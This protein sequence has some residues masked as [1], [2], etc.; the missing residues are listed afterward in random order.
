MSLAVSALDIP[1]LIR[2]NLGLAEMGAKSKSGRCTAPPAFAFSD[3]ASY[4]CVRIAVPFPPCFQFS[5]PLLDGM[6]V[7]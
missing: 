7:F 4:L 6:N 1:D 2:S 3:W 5:S